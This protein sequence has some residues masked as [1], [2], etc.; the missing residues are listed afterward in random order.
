MSAQYPWPGAVLGRGREVQGAAD[1]GRDELLLRPHPALP[2]QTV[3]T[4]Y[5]DVQNIASGM[6]PRIY[7]HS[8]TI[9]ADLVIPAG[10]AEGVMVAE[11]DHLGGFSLFVADGKLKHTYSMMGMQVYRHESGTPL[12]EGEVTV[13]LEF[14]ADAPKPAADPRQPYPARRTSASCAGQ[15]CRSCQARGSPRT[16]HPGRCR[17]DGPYRAPEPTPDRRVEGDQSLRRAARSAFPVV[18]R[19]DGQLSHICIHRRTRGERPRVSL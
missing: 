15:G 14:H 8:Y 1:A 9:E 16:D 18:A 3:Y 6:I 13:R 10:G 12:P 4:Y 17:A 19:P 2:E 11:A 5:G 7:N